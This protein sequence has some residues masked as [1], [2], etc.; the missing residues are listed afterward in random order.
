[1]HPIFDLQ[2]EDEEEKEWE[3][4][5]IKITLNETYG[6]ILFNLTIKLNGIIKVALT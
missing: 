1:M 5:M 6:F 4:N 2:E 3:E